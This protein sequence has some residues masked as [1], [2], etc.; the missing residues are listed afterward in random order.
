MKGLLIREPWIG[1]I[2]SGRKFWEMRSSRTHVR[3]RI[4]LI[5]SGTGL[6]VGTAVL[7]DCLP[8]LDSDEMRQST[9]FHG[10]P[11]DQLD[12][13]M[14]R[15]WTIPWV[16]SDV[17]A[18]P[19]PIPYKHPSGAV[20]WVDLGEQFGGPEAE[21]TSGSDKASASSSL[22]VAMT[23]TTAERSIHS[24]GAHLVPATQAGP[25]QTFIDIP[26]TQGN[27]NNHH[28]YLRHALDML[29]RDCIG[30]S[31][32]ASPGR[33]VVVI[34][35]P[36]PVVET[37]VDGDKRALRNRGAVRTFFEQSGCL[38]G[39]SVRFTRLGERQ[40]RVERIPASKATA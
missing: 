31:N 35:E 4:A 30:G 24:K 19:A 27:I 40:Y 21:T 29:P 1:M 25:V 3:G 32:R 6:V 23:A 15:G 14:A 34:F 33:P 10:L 8:A 26:L 38:A 5:R 39:D 17:R 18:L 13:V 7:S 2:L 11:L 22:K 20:T 9:A 37:D 28:F 12:E 36:G 16:L